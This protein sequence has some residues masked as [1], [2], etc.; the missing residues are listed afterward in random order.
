MAFSGDVIGHRNAALSDTIRQTLTAN[1]L[2]DQA[3]L[4]ADGV[5]QGIDAATAKLRAESRLTAL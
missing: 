3:R 2:G 4:A 5:A 1:L